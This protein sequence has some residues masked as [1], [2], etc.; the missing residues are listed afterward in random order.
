MRGTIADLVKAGIIGQ[1]TRYHHD[2]EGPEGPWDKTTEFA[3]REFRDLDS[4]TIG[5][6]IEFARGACLA[7]RLH[8]L[9]N[10]AEPLP[11]DMV[12][13]TEDT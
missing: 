5:K 3:F 12:P 11:A 1:I 10:P 7:A 8:K 6:I 4:L 13:K 9:C 2:V